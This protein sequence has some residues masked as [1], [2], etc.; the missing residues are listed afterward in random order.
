MSLFLSEVSQ[1]LLH[2]T[3]LHITVLHPNRGEEAIGDA[4]AA[5]L[6]RTQSAL[7][8]VDLPAYWMS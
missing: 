3:V 6:C 4:V 8:T 1:T 2:E 5:E 7:G